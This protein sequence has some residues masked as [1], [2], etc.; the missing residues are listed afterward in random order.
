MYDIDLIAPLDNVEHNEVVIINN[1]IIKFMIGKY[2][3]VTLIVR[4]QFAKLSVA[5]I[6]CWCK[7]NRYRHNKVRK[8]LA[9][10]GSV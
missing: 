10:V 5:F 7:S 2:G 3:S 6:V 8:T 9:I 1:P 4:E